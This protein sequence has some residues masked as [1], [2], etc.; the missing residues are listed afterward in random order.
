MASKKSDTA[1]SA[2]LA[3]KALLA[4]F[5][6]A[7]AIIGVALFSSPSGDAAPAML[8]RNVTGEGGSLSLSHDGGD[9][10]VR[11][12]IKILG[13]GVDRTDNFSIDGD[14]GW[15]S[16]ETGQI[17]VLGGVPEDAHIQIVAGGVSRTGGEWL[18]HEVGSG[19]VVGPTATATTMPTATFTTIPTTEPTQVPLVAGFTADPT[20]GPAPLPVQ[21][22]DAS[23]GGAT[24]WSWNFG[25]G[26]T[27]TERNPAHT[28]ANEGIYTVKLTVK[29]AKDS[30]TVTK[31][32][33]IIVTKEHVSRLEVN[34]FRQVLIFSWWYVPIN[35]ID[36]DY[37]GDPGTGSDRTPFVLSRTDS[38]DSGFNVTLKA[39]DK[40]RIWVLIFPI[41]VNFDGWQVGDAWYESRTI[42]VPVADDESRTATAYY[43][44]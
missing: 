21:F 42:S 11:E 27:S 35:D 19:S 15:T 14:S 41:T 12:D 40:V 22:T 9:P 23:A 36:I 34:S 33:Y 37:S 39:P 29:N 43:R 28:Y 6:T 31:T 20:S 18:L 25:D 3:T 30:D 24:S 8:A 10:L 38:G 4:V 17:L 5:V 44:F 2:L 7:A 32:G 13:N 26:G 16:W 1:A